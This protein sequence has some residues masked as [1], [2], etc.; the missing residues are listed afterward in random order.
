MVQLDSGDPDA[1]RYLATMYAEGLGVPQDAIAACSVAQVVSIV[2]NVNAPRYAQHIGAFDA[3]IKAA[4]EFINKHCNGLSSWDRM[5]TGVSLGC[6]AFGMSEQT[7]IVG[8]EAISAGRGG[9]WLRD[10]LPE[11]PE[12][13]Q[14]CF[15]RVGRVRAVNIAPPTDAAPGVVARHFVELLGWGMGA[16]PGTSAPIY[17]LRWQLYEVR[18]KKVEVVAGEMFDETDHWPEPGLIQKFDERFS[19]EMIRSGHIRWRLNGAPPK[20]GWIMLPDERSR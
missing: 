7:L 14:G 5:V 6:F 19:L 12:Q 11:R 17:V 4:D 15:A 20:R 2:T 1:A 10:A 8:G 9:I 18:G 13:L 16:R 3:A